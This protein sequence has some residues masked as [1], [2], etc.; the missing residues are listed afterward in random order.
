MQ[1]LSR[2]MTLAKNNS[3]K[4]LKILN[5]QILVELDGINIAVHSTEITYSIGDYFKCIKAWVS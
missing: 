4:R 2:K 5:F 1:L 3:D